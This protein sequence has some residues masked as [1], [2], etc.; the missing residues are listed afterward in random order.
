MNLLEQILNDLTRVQ[1]IPTLCLE[2]PEENNKKRSASA[3]FCC[4]EKNKMTGLATSTY[5][6]SHKSNLGMC[7]WRSGLE[8]CSA[9]RV[10][11]A[12]KGRQRYLK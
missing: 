11:P 6:G 2:K 4:L 3:L 1:N 5:C 10:N 12:F 7:G 9:I 8:R